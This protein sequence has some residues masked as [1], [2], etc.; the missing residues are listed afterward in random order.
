MFYLGV[1]LES[2]DL[3]FIHNN[4]VSIL[5]TMTIRYL[6]SAQLWGSLFQEDPELQVVSSV[7][8]NFFVDYNEPL[9]ALAI[10]KEMGSWSLE[11]LL[12]RHEFLMI[13]PVI[14]PSC[15]I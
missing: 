5:E 9:V 1:K 15:I 6:K 10:F 3:Y 14:W 13:L 4:A 12:D 7:F 2:V 11:E 8:T